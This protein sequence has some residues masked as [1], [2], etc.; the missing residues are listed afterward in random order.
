MKSEFLEGSRTFY[1]SLEVGLSLSGLTFYG[2]FTVYKRLPQGMT[3][4][5]GGHPWLY[6]IEGVKSHFTHF[7]FLTSYFTQVL[8]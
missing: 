5:P 7:L 8:W 1:H 4:Y 2:L 6:N 3:G